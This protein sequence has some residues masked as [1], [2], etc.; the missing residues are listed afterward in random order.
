MSYKIGDLSRGPCCEI[1]KL[2]VQVVGK[3]HPQS[4]RLAFYE[5][6]SSKPLDELTARDNPETVSAWMCKPSSL[7]VWDWDG[8]PDH[9][10]VLEVE[11][12]HGEII[13]LP[14]PEVR[15]TTRRMDRQENQIVPILPFVALPG[16]GSANDHGTPVLCRPGYIYVFID[17]RLWRELEIRLTGECTTYHDTDLEK[18]RIGKDYVNGS[19]T[20]TGK[21]LDD[22]WVPSSW[23]GARVQAQL[24]FSEVQLNAPRIHRLENDADLRQRRCQKPDLRVAWDSSQK[25]FRDKPEGLEML[26]AFS[27]FDAASQD[28][29]AAST[30]AYAAF[31]N[32][33]SQ[34][35]PLSIP[36]PQRARQ[37]GL[38]WMLDQPANYLCDLSGQYSGSA[39]QAARL[40]VQNCE[41][42][43][44]SY[45]P[46]RL[47]TGAWAKCLEQTCQ[48]YQSDDEL[49]QANPA[50]TDVLTKARARELH[51]VLLVDTQYRLRHL[52]VRIQ[53]QRHLL[54]LCA[55]RAQ[56]YPHHG[57]ALLVQ[58]LIAPQRIGGNSN[59]LHHK[60][61]SLEDQGRRDI[62]RFT[63]SSERTQLWRQLEV[64]QALL[65]EC[66]QSPVTE[67]SLA[68]HFSQNGFDYVAALYFVSQLFVTLAGRPSLHDPL[69]ASGDITDATTGL[70]L[71]SA[72]ASAGQK[73]IH[74]V[75][76]DPQHPVH[77]MLWPAA[78]QDM[79][80]PYQAPAEPDVNQGNG[81]FRGTELASVE[82][83]DLQPIE[84][85]ATI[86]S[87]F[88]AGLLKNGSLKNTLTVT[89][90]AGTAA[91]VAAAENMHSAVEAASRAVHGAQ[92]AAFHNPDT[93]P[94]RL[95]DAVH[96]RSLAQMRSMLPQ[97]F[98][99]MRFLPYEEARARD[100]YVFG[101]DDAPEKLPRSA[102]PYGVYRNQHGVLNTPAEES[103]YSQ[104]APVLPPERTVIGI[105]RNHRTA[106]AVSRINKQF[107]AAWREEMLQRAAGQSERVSALQRATQLRDAAQSSTLFHA[108]D[109]VPMAGLI[110]GLELYNLSNE[111]EAAQQTTRE[112]GGNRATL[113]II[114]AAVDLIIAME[115]LTVKV[116]SSNSSLT[117]ARKTVLTISERSAK[118]FL[119][120]LSGYLIKAYSSRMIAQIGAG[121]FFAGLNISDAWYS[122]RW[123]DD[124]YIGH[125]I[126]A[127]GGLMGAISSLITVGGSLLG[128]SPLGWISL[129]LI[130]AG[131]GVAYILSS[132]PI[133]DW[134]QTG[135]FGSDT[136]EVAPH[137]QDPSQAFYYLVSLMTNIQIRIDRN[138]DFLPDAKINYHD[139]VPSLIRAS[140]TRIRIESN[141]AGLIRDLHKLDTQTFLKL[142]T[143]K[144]FFQTGSERTRTESFKIDVSPLAHRL[145]PD[146]LE[147]FVHTPFSY[148]AE[149][150]ENL[151]AIYHLWQ[152]RAQIKVST[153][154]QAW[155]FPAPPPKDSTRYN[156]T[157][158]KPDFESNGKPFWADEK[159]NLASRKIEN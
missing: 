16:V 86:D 103:G 67:Q 4:Q 152:V 13:R 114:S 28:S 5:K 151:P 156:S 41:K 118:R 26:E 142:T 130:T 109:S 135:P 7:H 115:A 72:K 111:L 102:Q 20:A 133:D 136:Y 40:H 71:Y 10:M 49:W 63:A 18:F 14:L 139:T 9:R 69:A 123:N 12:E 8:E 24:C 58:Q 45:I 36:A 126:M 85:A 121:L 146:A 83:L 148:N 68:D 65:C 15:V 42:G 34:A 82:P 143:I 153:S 89:A 141:L 31:L 46:L 76:N 6:D 47:E 110:A 92:R 106:L 2:I 61:D 59:S 155:A 128:L 150:A 44:E 64:T 79:D 62:N 154:D 145:W 120:P 134:M 33:Q 122:Y 105:P 52:N 70:S 37:I 99:D 78:A 51:G 144:T 131:A 56:R 132:A 22:I 11:A 38:E 73:W 124:A 138:P 117:A 57:S 75:V 96:R 1:N 39:R 43:T 149:P 94:W 25:T 147:L 95:N 48:P 87:L 97:T 113:G 50:A 157:H 140:N 3:D 119:G 107:N 90:K 66:L 93:K 88:L 35:F 29:Q 129:F 30:K 21:A 98:G 54:Q 158:G 80:A 125:L 112:K 100:Y 77:E 23:N 159:E 116:V 17:G 27:Q 108:L 127:S 84:T 91:L 137:L 74:A 60:L 101:L 104:P 53:D 81:S 19:R 55:E 32:V